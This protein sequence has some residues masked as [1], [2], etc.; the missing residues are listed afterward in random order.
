MT[1]ITDKRAC[2]NDSGLLT[3]DC[4]CFDC[5]QLREDFIQLHIRK[6]EAYLSNRSEEEREGLV[7]SIEASIRRYKG[8]L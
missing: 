2:E 8:W 7:Q 4:D 5:T 1:T 3:R 6:A